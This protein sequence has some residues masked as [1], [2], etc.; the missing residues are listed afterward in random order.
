MTG[1]DFELIVSLLAVAAAGVAAALLLWRGLGRIYP[2]LLAFNAFEF[3]S[4]CVGLILPANSTRYAEFYMASAAVG[5]VIW[6]GLLR[7]LLRLVLD[8]QP[9]IARAARLA[10][11]VSLGTGVVLSAALLQT[12]PDPAAAQ[13]PLLSYFF[14]AYQSVQFTLA[15]LLLGV[16]LFMLRY[17]LRLRPNVLTYALGA[18]VLFV[19]KAIVLVLHNRMGEGVLGTLFSSANLGAGILCRVYWSLSMTRDGE[20]SNGQP[21]LGEG[22]RSQALLEELRALNSILAG[23]KG[24][25]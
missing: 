24:R 11:H 20:V 21:P 1:G 9:G 15:L 2:W 8:G 14:G 6:Y 3:V 4:G 5:T 7:E 16:A 19:F 17:P 13:F 18:T 25:R 22:D 12:N 10:A 23:P